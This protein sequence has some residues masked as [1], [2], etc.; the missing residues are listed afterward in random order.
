MDGDG[1]VVDSQT[2]TTNSSGTAQFDIWPDTGPGP[3]PRAGNRRG[4]RQRHVRGDV[5]PEPA[6]GVRER[7]REQLLPGSRSRSPASS[8]STTAS[9]AVSSSATWCRHGLGD[10]AHGRR[11]R[12]RRTVTATANDDGQYSVT[13]PG[14]ATAGLTAGPETNY[15]L[16]LAV[17]LQATYDDPTP[18]V[19]ARD[20]A[21]DV[22]PLDRL[23]R[24][25]GDDQDAAAAAARGELVRV[26]RRLGE[27]RRDVSLP[28][29]R[30]ELHAERRL[31]RRRPHSRRRRHDLHAGDAGG[32]LRH[33]GDQRRRDRLDGR[34]RAGRGRRRP[35]A[36]DARRRGEGRPARPGRADRLE[37]PV[38]D[39][40]ADLHGRADGNHLDEPRA[41]GDPAEGDLR[42]GALRRPAVPGRPRRLPGAQARHGAHG[43]QARDSHQ[44]A[45]V[46]GLDVQPLPGD[47]VRPAART[48]P[49]LGRDRDG[50]LGR[51]VEEPGAAAERL[52]VHDPVAARHTGH[53]T[54]VPPLP[55]LPERIVDGWYQPPGTPSTTAATRRA[56]GRPPALIGVGPRVGDI[57]R[58]CG[59][60]A[61]AVYDERSSPTP[62]S[63][64]WTTTP[65]RTA[66]STS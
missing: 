56:S 27:A 58:A 44:L 2:V 3:H 16:G 32:R 64:T 61:K 50:G 29:L 17:R 36:Q 15:E 47:V 53:A 7:D 63:T 14:S 31:G 48:A 25:L 12:P 35:C 10:A 11:P 62:R 42:H 21:E 54:M 34:Q 20:L 40:D 33:G 19:S 45:R 28:R 18:F 55:V 22:G 57:D 30:Q 38:L 51:R 39:G 52:P 66:S 5:P 9:P 26:G 37:E 65:T 23:G 41:E 6:R 43:R 13:F 59:P 24:R 4:A 60:T 1:T 46:R 8:R 49:S